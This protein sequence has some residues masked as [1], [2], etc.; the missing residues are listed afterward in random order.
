MKRYVILKKNT[1][2]ITFQCSEQWFPIVQ[3][4]K[5]LG[6]AMENEDSWDLQGEDN[7]HTGI[8]LPLSSNHL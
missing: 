4:M 7:L 5:Y 1:Q 3:S 2:H 6:S 8:K